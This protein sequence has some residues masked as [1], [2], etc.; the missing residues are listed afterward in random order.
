MTQADVELPHL[1]FSQHTHTEKKEEKRQTL[2][3][4]EEENDQDEGGGCR[5]SLV[6]FSLDL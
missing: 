1:Q 5:S 4:E 3:G 6:P 2:Q